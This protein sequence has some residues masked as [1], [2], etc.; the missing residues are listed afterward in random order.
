MGNPREVAPKLKEPA[1]LLRKLFYPDSALKR[2]WLM[3][4]PASSG[5]MFTWPPCVV[6]VACTNGQL[7]FGCWHFIYTATIHLCEVNNINLAQCK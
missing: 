5:H 6:L 4:F 7:E 2:M 1:S 3:K